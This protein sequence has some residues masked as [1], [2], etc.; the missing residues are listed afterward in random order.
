MNILN[1]LASNLPL[2]SSKKTEK[3]IYSLVKSCW[4]NKILER[5][6]EKIIK[7]AGRPDKILVIADVN[8][9]D[10]VNIQSCI[11]VVK[12]FLPS[13]RIDYVF[14]SVASPVI[15]KNSYIDN[16]Y[17][18]FKGGIRPDK[19]ELKQL[20]QI[21]LK[22]RYDLII[23]FSPFISDKDLKFAPCPIITPT[24]ITTEIL[25]AKN[26]GPGKP[27]LVCNIIK[28]SERFGSKLSGEKKSVRSKSK[29]RKIYIS[30]D[31]VRKRNDFCLK[32]GIMHEHAIV[33]LNPDSSSPY[34]LID[35][36]VQREL[37]KRLVISDKVDFIIL[38]P[39]YKYKNIEKQITRG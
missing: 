31:A 21:I 27:G 3:W 10:A 26:S 16:F 13:T 12:D 28:Y 9:G 1:I 29:G 33:F 6:Q 30:E 23:N 15:N 8:I 11:E 18:L 4:F 20:N 14:N 36:K 24:G 32:K 34:T 17:P 5:K 2:F 19:E 38:N 35:K 25:R 7:K 39:G 22:N 37:I